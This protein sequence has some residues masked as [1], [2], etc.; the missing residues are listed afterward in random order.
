MRADHF[1]INPFFL[2][3]DKQMIQGTNL[4]IKQVLPV[5][6]GPATMTWHEFP[7]CLKIIVVQSGR[8]KNKLTS[9]KKPGKTPGSLPRAPWH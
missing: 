2:R 1:Q 9:T 5:A 7:Q 4:S 6:A 3:Q 8:L